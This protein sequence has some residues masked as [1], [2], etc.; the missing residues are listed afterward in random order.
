MTNGTISEEDLYEYWEAE[1]IKSL[2]FR[3]SLPIPDSV[4]DLSRNELLEII[5][6][7]RADGVNGVSEKL[8]QM[9]LPFCDLKSE[10]YIPL[11]ERHYSHPAIYSLF[12]TA[13]TGEEIAD[14]IVSHKAIQL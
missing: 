7:I 12:S 11:L 13:L 2:A 14:A 1:D 10:F 5:A 9:G 6:R 4:G 8:V 3:L